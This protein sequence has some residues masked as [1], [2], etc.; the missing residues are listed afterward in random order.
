[1]TLY[2]NCYFLKLTDQSVALIVS[3][4]WVSPVQLKFQDGI[5]RT[6]NQALALSKHIALRDCIDHGPMKTSLPT[7]MLLTF[8]CN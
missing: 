5:S 2:F 1:M 7:E 3:D 4:K 8:S 6:L